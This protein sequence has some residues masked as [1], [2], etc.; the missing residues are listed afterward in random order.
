[1]TTHVPTCDPP[2]EDWPL[3][4]HRDPSAPAWKDRHGD[5]WVVGPDGLLWTN[6]TRPFPREL[7]ERKW[8]P[9][10]EVTP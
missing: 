3:C 1:M 4:R 5:V 10:V 9:L 7:V 8:G 6:E 2:C